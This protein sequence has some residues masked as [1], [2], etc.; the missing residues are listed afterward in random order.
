MEL[1][2]A[3]TS[4]RRIDLLTAMG[5][6]F[7]VVAPGCEESVAGHFT[8]RELSLLNAKR[9]SHAVAAFAPTAIVIGADT[10]VALDGECIGKPAD[11]DEA[12]RM[13]RKLSGR[14]HQVV[15]SVWISRLHPFHMAAFTE[16]S[17]V[18]FRPLS[19]REIDEYLKK[20]DPLDKAGGYAAQEFRDEIISS[21]DGALSN[22]I[23]LPTEALE[24]ALE[25][26]YD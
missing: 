26:F 17:D 7:R 10:V 22:V 24:P 11:L 3:S 20:I 15:T 23:G 2:L 12:R 4:P 1:V 19:A 16:I 21:I 13:L 8:P 14:T 5:R 9:K 6:P 25:N 18:T